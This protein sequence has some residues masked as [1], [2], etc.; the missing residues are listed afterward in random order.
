[1]KL[2]LMMLVTVVVYC[3]VTGQA[4][5]DAAKKAALR[6]TLAK[7]PVLFLKVASKAMKWE[8]ASLPVHVA[9]PIYFVGT[10]GLASY[11]IKSSEG[12]IVLYTGMP[13]SGPMIE[14]SIKKL[15]F[16]P[17]DIKLLI[18]GH[19]HSDHVGGMQYLQKISG[20][21][22][23]LMEEEKD[24]IE[25]GG[26]TDF[27]YGDYPVYYYPPVTVDRSLK[28]NDVVELGNVKLTALLT[29]GHT[30]GGTTWVMNITDQGKK[31]KVVFPD[32][33]SINPGYR[34]SVN[35]SYP[36]IQQ[37]YMRTLDI[38]EGLKPD[39]WLPSHTDFF[40][41]EAK[42]KKKVAK[43]N[44]A[45]VDPQGYKKYIAGA[46]TTYNQVIKSEMLATQ[47]INN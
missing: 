30:K 24:L 3:T 12:L 1:M 23:A 32:G 22:I 44:N 27:H 26:K 16:N 28:D 19:A 18:T 38:L 7:D 46:R 42:S 45:F 37:N 29:P 25:S 31:Y 35:P 39:I 36:G 21:K 6:D 40:D 20:A 15:G 2:F 8:A 43:G 13:S 10:K 17:K 4:P 41:F 34:V 11:L 33:I 14:Q 5:V 47:K 9:G